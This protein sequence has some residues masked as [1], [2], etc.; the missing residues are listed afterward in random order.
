MTVGKTVLT[1]SPM[2][3]W[4]TA[5]PLSWLVFLFCSFMINEKRMDLKNS[6]KGFMGGFGERIEQGKVM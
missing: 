2:L 5:H 4:T 3:Q 1:E 6:R